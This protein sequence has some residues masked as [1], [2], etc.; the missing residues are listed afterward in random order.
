M[1][2]DA[3]IVPGNIKGVVKYFINVESAMEVYIMI[4]YVQQHNLQYRNNPFWNRNITYH[5]L[6]YL[7]MCSESVCPMAKFILLGQPHE[8]PICVPCHGPGLAVFKV[9]HF[10]D[11]WWVQ[12][13]KEGVRCI[14]TSPDPRG[15]THSG[16]IGCWQMFCELITHLHFCGEF[17]SSWKL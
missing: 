15:E 16:I 6:E 4:I 1:S 17:V 9:S 12:N 14:K 5:H 7:A 8:I 11:G 2:K 10:W 3:Q 13:P